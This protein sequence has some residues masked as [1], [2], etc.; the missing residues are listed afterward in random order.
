L[1]AFN[2]IDKVFLEVQRHQLGVLF[3]SLDL[4]DAYA[5]FKRDYLPLPSKYRH[6]SSVKTSKFWIL[7]N[8][9][10]KLRMIWNTFV[11]EEKLFV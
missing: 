4:V 9:M 3:E 8:P 10:V 11:V 1:Q 6:L 5:C 2:L 7:V